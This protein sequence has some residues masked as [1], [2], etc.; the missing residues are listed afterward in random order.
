MKNAECGLPLVGFEG[1]ADCSCVLALKSDLAVP[2][3]ELPNT[4][5]VGKPAGVNEF[6]AEGGGPAGV[7]EGLSARLKVDLG[8]WL[9]PGV[10][11]GLEE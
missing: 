2:S 6:V 4:V 11:G 8:R 10:E 1:R 7:V 5:E 9:L 3:W